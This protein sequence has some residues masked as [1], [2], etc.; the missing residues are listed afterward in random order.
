MGVAITPTIATYLYCGIAADTGC[1]RYPNV[2]PHTFETAAKLLRLGA[3]ATKVNHLL[4]ETKSEA[5][6]SLEQYVFSKLEFLFAQKCAL[7]ILPKAVIEALGA[8]E[9]DL[10]GLSNLAKVYRNVQVAVMLRELREQVYKISVR[11]TKESHLDAGAIC[12][13]LGG[14]GHLNSAGCTVK[15]DEATAKEQICHAVAA[16][17]ASTRSN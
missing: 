15:A 12:A 11:T 2:I 16:E 5:R 3:N 6:I 1:F 13:R 7:F 14:G 9:N 17:I 8:E 4:F 10:I